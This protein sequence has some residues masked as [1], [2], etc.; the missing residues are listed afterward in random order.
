MRTVGVTCLFG[1]LSACATHGNLVRCDGKLEPINV[2][3]SVE[4]PMIAPESDSAGV[5]W[6]RE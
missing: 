6:R 1:V 3:H 2:P 5:R 4:K